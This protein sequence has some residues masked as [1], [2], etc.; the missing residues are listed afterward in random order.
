MARRTA[1]TEPPLAVLAS[2]QEALAVCAEG[3]AALLKRKNTL[4][5][6]IADA[7]NAR[8][9]KSRMGLLAGVQAALG[10]LE[11]MLKFAKE[12]N[13]T[14][15]APGA[16]SRRGVNGKKGKR[17]A[18]ASGDRWSHLVGEA[19]PVPDAKE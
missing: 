2:E 6:E 8:A 19:V 4:M 17:R 7:A 18:Q 5:L 16:S 13:A 3:M 11:G 12:V 9:M 14:P 10:E 1:K 15:D